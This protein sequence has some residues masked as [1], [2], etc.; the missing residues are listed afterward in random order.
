[1]KIVFVGDAVPP[2]VFSEISRVS[3]S[4]N[5]VELM[6]IDMLKKAYGDSFIV[7]TR[8][9]G[10][11][12]YV[13]TPQTIVPEMNFALDN[14]TII[15][16]VSFR[17]NR[18]SMNISALFSLTHKLRTIKR[19]YSNESFIYVVNNHFYGLSLPVF[20]SK[21]EEDTT[22]TIV[23]E[24]FDVRYLREHRISLKDYIHNVI[25]KYIFKRNDGII[26]FCAKTVAE[27][28]SNVPHINLLY[29]CSAELFTEK[30]N[31]KTG[32]S[33]RHNIL[34]AGLFSPC[35]GILCLIDTMKYLPDNYTL[36]LCGSGSDDIVA[37]VKAVAAIDSRIIYKGMLPRAEVLKIE[38]E[39][40]VLAMIR[41][42]N[43]VSE[44]YLA[45]YCQPSKLPEYMLSGTPIIATDINGI[46]Q[47]LKEYVNMT[48]TTSEAIAKTIL[49]VCEVNV[50]NAE[51]KAKRAYMFA[52][53]NCS[54]EKQGEDIISFINSIADRKK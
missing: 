50:K 39:S 18:I 4:T 25:H 26:T 41:V 30:K 15:H 49:D 13:G 31:Y 44:K 53:D 5:N 36:T 34:Y 14:G 19:K 20:F 24:G 9:F 7:I 21:K 35:Y 10:L 33:S 42:A 28:A 17:S 40:D 6:Y 1:M 23:N 22:I 11:K 45:E 16:T 3:P 48:E 2:E 8:N 38:Q 54:I 32:E 12:T 29:A 47:C 51:D 27:N 46:P 37:Q 43:T 52:Q